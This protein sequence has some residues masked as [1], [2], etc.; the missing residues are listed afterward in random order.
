[1]SISWIDWGSHL[2]DYYKT[3]YILRNWSCESIYAKSQKTP[4]KCCYMNSSISNKIMDMDCFF[5][6]NGY[7]HI[8]GYSYANWD[9]SQTDRRPLYVSLPLSEVISSLGRVRSKA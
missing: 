6:N 9:G 8:K 4:F 7:L 5:R 3:G 2:L 1:M